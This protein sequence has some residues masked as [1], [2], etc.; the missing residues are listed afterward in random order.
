MAF[1]LT[2]CPN[3]IEVLN[4]L[5]RLYEQHVQDQI[6]VRM[7]VPTLTMKQF[8]IQHKAGY[9]EYPDPEERIAFWDAYL[10]ERM[11]IHDDSIPSGALL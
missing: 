11:A 8:A 1:P 6:F 3:G 2:Y 9:C 5:R 7:E 4:R 10:R